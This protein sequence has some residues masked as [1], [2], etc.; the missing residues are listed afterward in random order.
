MVRKKLLEMSKSARHFR[1]GTTAMLICL[2]LI[3]GYQLSQ[4]E[5]VRIER[6]V[7]ASGEGLSKR[8][9]AASSLLHWQKK[10]RLGEEQV[11]ILS[12]LD[13]QE[14]AELKP[15]EQSLS[16]MTSMMKSNGSPAELHMNISQIQALAKE[17]AA[18]SRRKREIV[19]RFSKQAWQVL[20][21]QQQSLASKLSF[22]SSEK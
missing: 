20:G 4:P 13:N 14:K 10:L 2:L 3:V 18:P 22:G 5:K 1:S 15:I 6:R 7:E 9:P 8:L 12:D 16:E 19:S 21:S 17:V 11:K